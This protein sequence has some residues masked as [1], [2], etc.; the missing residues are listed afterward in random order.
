MLHVPFN[1][2]FEMRGVDQLLYVVRYDE[3]SILYLRCSVWAHQG[4]S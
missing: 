2:L 1:S 3:L 4:S